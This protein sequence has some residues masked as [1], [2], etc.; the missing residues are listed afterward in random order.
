VHHPLSPVIKVGLRHPGKKERKC[1]LGVIN[2]MRTDR[3]LSLVIKLGIQ[4]RK[5]ELAR[6]QGNPGTV[7]ISQYWFN[8]T[9]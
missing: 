8:K 3:P 9:K 7:T 6:S 4:E 1:P 2:P 5:N